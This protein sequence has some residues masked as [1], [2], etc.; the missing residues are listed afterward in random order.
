MPRKSSLRLTPEQESAL[1]QYIQL[2]IAELES[3]NQGR[4][5]ADRAS[6]LRYENDRRDRVAP[7]SIW[8]HS[9][10]P[11]PL[12]SLVVD[13]F[14]S[15][16]WDEIF[17]NKPFFTARPQGP[18]D[19]DVAR[20]L[21]RFA[22]FKLVDQAHADEDIEDAITSAH[23]QRAAIVKAIYHEETDD[24]ERTDLNALH[25]S[26]TGQPVEILGHGYILEDDEWEEQPDPAAPIDPMTGAPGATRVHLKADPSF[27]M[28]PARHAFAPLQMPVA[29]QR[30]IFKGAKSVEVESQCFLA[31]DDARSLEEADFVAEKYDKTGDWLLDRFTEREGFTLD[32]YRTLIESSDANHKTGT[33]DE[34]PGTSLVTEKEGVK[35]NLG[36]DVRTKRRAVVECWL[37]WDVLQR[38]RPQ[39]LVVWWDKEAA[40]AVCYDYQALV[41][42]TGRHPYRSLV[43]AKNK[44]R[45]WGYSLPEIVQAFQDYVDLQFNR[46]SYRNSINANPI[47]GQNP[48]AIQEKKSFHELKPFEVVTLE[49]G[50]SIQEYLQ[51]FVFPNADLDT[52]V[53]LDKVF[54]WVQLWLGISNVAQGDY[55][56]TPQNTT[57]FGQDATLKEAAKLSRRFSRRLQRGV[58]DHLFDLVQVLIA[59]MDEEEAFYFMEGDQSLTGTLRADQV[60]G[61]SIDISLVVGAA[62]NAQAIQAAQ[63]A[64][65]LVEKYVTMLTTAPAFALVVRPIY[66][67]SLRLLGYDDVDK[68]LPDP[69]DPQ[70]MIPPPPMTGMVPE[71]SKDQPKPPGEGDATALPDP[72]SPA[73]TAAPIV[74]G[75][76]ATLDRNGEGTANV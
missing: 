49:G 57:A 6:R 18:S 47:L 61:L 34:A 67:T 76:P 68:L 13:Y 48:D 5:D 51:A 38:G 73:N 69:T 1:N 33:N 35:E 12:T 42:P 52:E 16:S 9:N 11:V 41:S 26:T 4:I 22:T 8:E 40:R 31:P 50:K 63:L 74:G 14:L 21:E 62:S 43:L 23:L 7:D 46:H 15:R 45:W 27:V 29:I 17:G 39:R 36:F 55:S 10:T 28:D 20:A 32:D 64:T 60:R 56:D 25:D 24:F 71:G 2:R 66:K 59:T 54:Y 44:K 30:T 58:R 70:A 65:Q 53:L 37:T 19:R 3:T 72:G 75:P